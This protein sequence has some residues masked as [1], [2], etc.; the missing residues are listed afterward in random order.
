MGE[1]EYLTAIWAIKNERAEFT[2]FVSKITQITEALIG[3]FF[4]TSGKV[5][6]FVCKITYIMKALIGG[7]L[8]R[9]HGREKY[10]VLWISCTM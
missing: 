4:N 6:R 2:G 7:I 9:L 5:S 10:N 1:R 8:T 3:G